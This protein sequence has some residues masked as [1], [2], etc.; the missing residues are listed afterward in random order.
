[1]PFDP[2]VLG[3]GIR[4]QDL[5]W[6]KSQ[7]QDPG[8]GMKNPDHI[9]E[10]L[11]TIFWVTLTR[12]RNPGSVMEKIQIWDQGSEKEKFGSGIRDPG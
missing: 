7:D 5:G 11:E 1:M 4:N 3:S 10:S 2:W 8:S 12:I 6:V 9:S